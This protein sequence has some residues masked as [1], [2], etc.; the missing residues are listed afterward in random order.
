MLTALI[1]LCCLLVM[2]FIANIGLDLYN[3]ARKKQGRYT[4][5][6]TQMIRRE[7]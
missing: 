1:V 3:I 2:F 7:R 4:R 6:D 5:L